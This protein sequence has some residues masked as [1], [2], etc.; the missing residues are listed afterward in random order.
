MRGSATVQ[1]RRAR[2]LANEA[3][4]SHTAVVR[5][6]TF[7]A[8]TDRERCQLS[9]DCTEVCHFGARFPDEPTFSRSPDSPWAV[10]VD[11]FCVEAGVHFGALI[12]RDTNRS[13]RRQARTKPAKHHAAA[14]VLWRP[15]CKPRLGPSTCS[16]N[17]NAAILRV[18][19]PMG[20]PCDACVDPPAPDR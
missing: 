19:H 10:E 14:S 20:L 18:V 4:G 1:R 13:G 12:A 2:F 11:G 5:K 16:A 6:G 3:I 8:R 7:V 15:R 17:P 9:G